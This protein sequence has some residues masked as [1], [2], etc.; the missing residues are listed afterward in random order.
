MTTNRLF[1][2]FLFFV[3]TTTTK[4]Q[5]GCVTI[6]NC[7]E[8]LE[9]EDGC[10]WAASSCLESCDVI[11]DVACFDTSDGDS[12]DEICLLVEQQEQEDALCGGMTSCSD[13]V[14]TSLLSDPD[15]TCAWF[16]EFSTCSSEL[17]TMAGCGSETCDEKP[18]PASCDAVDKD[19]TT[20]LTDGCAWIDGATCLESCDIIADANCY[21]SPEDGDATTIEEVCIQA[22]QEAQDTELCTS[23]ESCTECVETSLISDASNVCTWYADL[24]ECCTTSTSCQGFGLGSTTCDDEK[25][26]ITTDAPSPTPPP[27]DLIENS[28]VCEALT[29]CRDC[30]ME[31]CAW[32][33]GA[34]C[35]E[36]CDIIADV[37]CYS[38]EDFAAPDDDAEKICIMAEQEL[39]DIELC[40]GKLGCMEC[41]NTRLM[42]GN[43]GDGDSTSCIWNDEVEECCT[44]SVMCPM[45]GLGSSTC[46]NETKTMAPTTETKPPLSPPTSAPGTPSLPGAGDSPTTAPGTPSLP[47]GGN[48][49]SG[50][51]TCDTHGDCTSCLSAGCGWADGT[52]P[53]SCLDSCDLIADTSCF[54]HND[55]LAQGR[56]SVQDM[57]MMDPTQRDDLVYCQS[58]SSSGCNECVTTKLR[59]DETQSCMWFED[60]GSCGGSSGDD[61]MTGTKTCSTTGTTTTAP[62]AP[63]GGGG[64]TPSSAPTTGETSSANNNIRGE[65]LLLLAV[66]SALQV[67]VLFG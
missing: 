55:A 11:A 31:E 54:E 34:G 10:A 35:F 66:A 37:S 13:C 23:R 39:S 8:C 32:A 4:A 33:S 3:A 64:T 44:S 14:S 63:S 45:F 9:S 18:P 26:E 36:S 15:K 48:S 50:T 2:L 53:M 46:S 27:A 62:S 20:C 41:V 42:S 67:V 30:V 49:T 6:D 22:D 47:E 21:P 29:G 58:K 56:M 61:S 52:T 5:D 24:G 60:M 12:S 25:P 16:E 1:L 19:C 51:A 38:F 28:T 59:S 7:N 57:C 43:G 65:M 17:C 40:Q